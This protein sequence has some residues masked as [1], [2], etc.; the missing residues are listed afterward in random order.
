MRLFVKLLIIFALIA[1]VG[2]LIHKG[3]E[4]YVFRAQ[5][6]NWGINQE[7]EQ[8]YEG[9]YKNGDYAELVAKFDLRCLELDSWIESYGGW[10]SVLSRDDF[11]TWKASPNGISAVYV[12]FHP[13][14]PYMS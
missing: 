5:M 6:H 13:Y 3:R 9:M 14:M 10:E 1:V 2:F 11:Q 8:D 7:L 12:H 4:S